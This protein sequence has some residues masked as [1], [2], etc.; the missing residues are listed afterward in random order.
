MNLI[1][2]WNTRVRPTSLSLG[3]RAMI[4]S[5]IGYARGGSRL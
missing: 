3:D 1:G 5:S 2:S 4:R